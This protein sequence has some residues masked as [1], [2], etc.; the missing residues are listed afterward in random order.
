MYRKLSMYLLA[1]LLLL[2]PVS[3]AFGGKAQAASSSRI[4]VI[5]QLSGDVQVQK[6]GGSKQF[7]AF[8]KLSLNQGDKLI[9]GSKGSAVLQFSNGTSEDD[10]FTVGE[11][12]TLTFSK[13]SDKKGHGDEGQ[14][15][16]RNGLGGRQVDQEPRR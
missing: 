11:N 15:A 2:L 6:A 7:K 12:A 13:L 3:A 14:H 16:Q 1:A 9:T 8:A 5:K 4:A 10:K